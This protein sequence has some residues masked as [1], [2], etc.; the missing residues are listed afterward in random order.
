MRL[1]NYKEISESHFYEVQNQEKLSSIL[2]GKKHA[3][4]KATFLKKHK[5]DE[6]KTQDCDKLWVKRVNT[7]MKRK[8][9][10]V[11]IL[12]AALILALTLACGFTSVVLLLLSII[13]INTTYSFVCQ[14]LHKKER[15]K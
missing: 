13:F 2:S 1:H 6:Y 4:S 15:N 8:P 9:K 3:C 7:R 11:Y 14:I 10:S 5:N 12:S